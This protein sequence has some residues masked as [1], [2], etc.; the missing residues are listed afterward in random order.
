M[1]KGGGLNGLSGSC[2]VLVRDLTVEFNMMLSLSV[3]RC[4]NAVLDSVF[5]WI[6]KELGLAKPQNT[7]HQFENLSLVTYFFNTAKN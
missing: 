1:Y 7:L 6:L 4:S 2:E 3:Q 5:I